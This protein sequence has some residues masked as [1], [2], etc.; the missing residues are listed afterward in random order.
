MLNKFLM[1]L[2]GGGIF[3]QTNK[4]NRRQ[5]KYAALNLTELRTF[6]EK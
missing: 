2:G 5:L 4:T 1:I 3:P 6:Q